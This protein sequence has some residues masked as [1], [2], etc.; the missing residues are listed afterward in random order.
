MIIDLDNF[1]YINDTLGHDMGD[2]VLR[3]FSLILKEIFSENSYIGRFGGDEFLVF[4]FNQESNIEIENKA[5]KL[6]EKMKEINDQY[7]DHLSCS[8]GICF[9]ENENNFENLFKKSDKALYMCKNSGKNSY[10]VYKNQRK[11]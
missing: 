8:I 11:E 5:N 3:K 9:V 2:Q 6:L 7:I 10:K 4:I 1:K